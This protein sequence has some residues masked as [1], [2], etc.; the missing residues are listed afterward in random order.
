MEHATDCPRAQSAN[1][2]RPFVSKKVIACHRCHAKKI[3][4]SGGQPCQSCSQPE[5]GTKCSYPQRTRTVKVPQS[6]ID[7]LYEEISRLKKRKPSQDD[8]SPKRTPDAPQCPESRLF[9]LEERQQEPTPPV[10]NEVDLQVDP[11]TPAETGLSANVQS[12]TNESPWFDNSNIFR[13]PILNSEP[14]DTVFATRFRQ[15]ISDSHAPQPSH[16][17]RLDY[18]N[19]RVL[20]TLVE[21]TVPWPSRSRARFLVEAALKYISRCHY[22]VPSDVTREGLAQVFLSHS[23][24]SPALCCKFWALF[25]LGELYV[26]RT[27]ATRS[28]PGMS[29]FAQASKML[30]YLDERPAK[31]G[32]C[33]VPY[34]SSDATHFAEPTYT[35]N[36]FQGLRSF[37]VPYPYDLCIHQLSIPF[38]SGEHAETRED[39]RVT[40]RVSA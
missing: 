21:S 19:D 1:P 30:G 7:G 40:R 14:A 39:C 6:F 28:Y 18:A 34:V 24:A 38:A 12:N 37:Y 8:R 23:P 4:C 11:E 22:I 16:L 15:I 29:Y 9:R 20:M 2:R 31:T 26:T 27:A 5:K 3:K 32:R 33:I 13:T 17:L 10:P 25:A 36:G 35:L